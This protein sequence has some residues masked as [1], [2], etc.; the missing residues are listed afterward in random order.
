MEFMI[1]V[2]ISGSEDS[3]YQIFCKGLEASIPWYDEKGENLHFKFMS[4]SV[5]IL[6]YYFKD[7]GK[8][9][10][11]RT[12]IVKESEDSSFTLPGLNKTVE[13]LYEGSGRSVDYMKMAVNHFEKHNVQTIYTLENSF[14]KRLGSLVNCHKLRNSDLNILISE[15]L[16]GK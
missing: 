2:K 4:E 3:I 13:I 6:F 10:F 15:Y 16:Q 7:E 12:Y 14:W 11:R 9:L 8:T 1:T 5:M